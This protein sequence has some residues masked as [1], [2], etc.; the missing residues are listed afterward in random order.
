MDDL[1]HL[2]MAAASALVG[3]CFILGLA[4]L[5]EER[6]VNK[7]IGAFGLGVAGWASANLVTS[8]L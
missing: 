4:N 8:L 2:E 7:I 5:F 3:L 1:T 6:L